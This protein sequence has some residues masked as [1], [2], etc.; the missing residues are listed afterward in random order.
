MQWVVKLMVV[1]YDWEQLEASD[2]TSILKD[3]H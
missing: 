2:G 3:G 1:K